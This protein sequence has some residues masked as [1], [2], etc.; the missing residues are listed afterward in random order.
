MESLPATRRVPGPS[1]QHQYKGEHIP[2]IVSRETG[3]IVPESHQ[4]DPLV[5][6]DKA[7]A[8]APPFAKSWAHFVAGG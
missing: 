5:R 8:E 2:L 3:D 7:K 4:A 6:P 1:D